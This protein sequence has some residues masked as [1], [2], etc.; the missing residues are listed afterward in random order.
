[1]KKETQNIF[2]NKKAVI[3]QAPVYFLIT[4]ILFVALVSFFV[5]SYFQIKTTGD[6]PQK[7]SAKSEALV[8]LQGFL[9]TPVEVDMKLD[10]KTQ[11]EKVSMTMT[12]L[13]RL[14]CMDKI[15]YPYKSQ[16]ESNAALILTKV[17]KEGTSSY[18]SYNFYVGVCDISSN[19]VGASPIPPSTDYV[20]LPLL[21]PGKED[22][23]IQFEIKRNLKKA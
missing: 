4:I 5:I 23:K 20:E 17:Y 19:S 10:G 12:D 13:I 3:A 1:M 6:L 21:V 7:F 14:Y 11:T 18:F 2:C 22:V 8:T 9:A 16:I 15:K